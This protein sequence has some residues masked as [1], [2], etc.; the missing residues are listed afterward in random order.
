MMACM[1]RFSKSRLLLAIAPIAIGTGLLTA[2]ENFYP[3]E[4]VAYVSLILTASA[5]VGSGFGAF[6]SQSDRRNDHWRSPRPYRYTIGLMCPC[7]RG[8]MAGR[9]LAHSILEVPMRKSTFAIALSFLAAIV[10]LGSQLN[11]PRTAEN[12]KPAVQKWEY[13]LFHG[14]RGPSDDRLKTAGEKGWEACGIAPDGSTT[15]NVIV[16]LKRP[17][18]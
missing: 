7:A 1:F 13:L 16:L 11:Q 3:R 4:R 14:F 8:R 9:I 5:I 17:I 6:L 10:W 2:P 12:A 15:E 18:Q